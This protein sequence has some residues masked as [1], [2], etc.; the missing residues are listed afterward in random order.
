M[1][2]EA[3]ILEEFLQVHQHAL[4]NSRDSQYLFG[5]G[6]D[7]FDLLRMV[8]NGLG[9]VAVGADAKRIL[10]VDFQHVGSFVQNAGDGLVIHGLKIKQD[11]D[12]GLERSM[13]QSGRSGRDG[14]AASGIC[15]WQAER[16]RRTPLVQNSS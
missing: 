11:W 14:S 2:A 9:G 8:L 5:L 16:E 3:A 15:C 10:R 13:A 1:H 12:A 4:A 7:V 6:D